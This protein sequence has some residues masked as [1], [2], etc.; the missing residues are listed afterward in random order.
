MVD[1]TCSCGRAYHFP[2]AAAGK[3][4]RCSACAAVFEVPQ[5]RT[6]DAPP[7]RLNVAPPRS[8]PDVDYQLAPAPPKPA[9]ARPPATPPEK[10]PPRDPEAHA[11]ER[12]GGFWADATLAFAFIRKPKNLVTWLC[13]AVLVA[14]PRVLDF[15]PLMGLVG[16]ITYALTVG[17]YMRT[18]GTSAAGEDE[19]PD[20]IEYDN[21][22]DDLV[23]PFLKWLCTMLVVIAPGIITVLAADSAGLDEDNAWLLASC[24]GI[25]CAA[26]W[27]SLLLQ[28]SLMGLSAVIRVDVAVRTIFAAPLPYFGAAAL[29]LLAFL[30]STLFAG[31]VGPEDMQQ[32]IEDFWASLAAPGSFLYGLLRFGTMALLQTYSTIVAM[33]VTGLFY[34]HTKDRLPWT[35]G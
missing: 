28:V 21:W 8:Q 15:V 30:A 11:E 33:R 32:S 2:V 19:L 7:T 27:P 12:F 18:V 17:F 29:I 14:F 4:A 16:L 10:R 1:F 24:V 26:L 22:F 34:F 20:L 13:A 9:A 3:K 5:A 23:M 6:P 35:A 25:A 31:V